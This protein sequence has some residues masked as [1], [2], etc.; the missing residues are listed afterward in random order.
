MVTSKKDELNSKLFLR[1]L[2]SAAMYKLPCTLVLITANK[3]DHLDDVGFLLVYYCNLTCVH[4]RDTSTTMNIHTRA[5]VI[6]FAKNVS[7]VSRQ[8]TISLN[9]ERWWG[10][11]YPMIYSA[12]LY[13]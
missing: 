13:C 4:Y 2:I 8:I 5:H 1:I 6:F 10:G 12:G 3:V 9:A 7:A 11:G